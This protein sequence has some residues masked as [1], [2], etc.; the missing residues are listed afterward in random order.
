MKRLAIWI[1]LVAVL[2]PM[3]APSPARAQVVFTLGNNPQPGEE[4]VLLNNANQF[5][6]TI[7]GTTQQSDIQVQFSS[8]LN[9]DEPPNGQARVEAVSGGP[10][11][12]PVGLT[13]VTISAPGFSFGDL[14]FNPDI[15]GTIG[16]KGGNAH[17]TAVATDGTFTFDY[18][19]GNGNNFLT[20]TTSG[21][22][23]MSSVSISY[24]LPDGFTDLRQVRISG[25]TAAAVPEPGTLLGACALTLVG[26]GYT[27]YRRGW[28]PRRRQDQPARA[29]GSHQPSHAP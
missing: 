21:G 15:T 8:T 29:G 4:N 11:S 28:G 5:G 16:T 25:L 3:L 18:T 22:E 19:L 9:L 7:F 10:G 2:S 20:L 14:I 26:L 17:I 24:S 13:N 27:W 6:T 1:G 23:L 12:S